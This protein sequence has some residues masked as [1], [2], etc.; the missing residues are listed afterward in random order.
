MQTYKSG[1]LGYIGIIGECIIYYTFYR[2]ND[3]MNFVWKIN[4]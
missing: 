2:I 4:I 3:I 1:M